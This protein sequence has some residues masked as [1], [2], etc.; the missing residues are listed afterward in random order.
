LCPGTFAGVGLAIQRLNAHRAH[1]R[2]DVFASDHNTAQA[3]QIAQHAG[4]RKR[5]LQV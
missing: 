4:A 2:G 3:Q 5:M 1:Q